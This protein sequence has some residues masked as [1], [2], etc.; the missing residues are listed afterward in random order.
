MNQKAKKFFFWEQAWEPDIAG[1]L[2]LSDHEFDT[3][4]YNMLRALIDKVDSRQEHTGNVS[5]DE[6]PKKEP[7]GNARD[8]NIVTEM[9]NTLYGLIR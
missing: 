7:K 4:M 6:N 5:R 8:K 2:D 9:K 1:M 3:T